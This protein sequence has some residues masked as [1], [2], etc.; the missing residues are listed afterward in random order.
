LESMLLSSWKSGNHKKRTMCCTHTHTHTDKHPTVAES[1]RSQ[2]EES[3]FN[4]GISET[5]LERIGGTSVDN[6]FSFQKFITFS[7]KNW[8]N[9]ISIVESQNKYTFTTS[10]VWYRQLQ[11]EPD[12][13]N[14]LAARHFW[15]QKKKCKKMLENT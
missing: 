12:N 1:S 8:Q 5:R 11:T 3:K 6:W 14:F 10:I 13:F 7:C 4:Y 2:K 9:F 15:L